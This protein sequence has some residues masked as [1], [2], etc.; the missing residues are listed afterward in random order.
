MKKLIKHRGSHNQYIK[1][2]TYEAI[3][4]AFDDNLYVGVEFD[5]RETLDHEFVIYHNSLYK[6][7]PISSIKYLELPKYIPRLRDILKIKTAKI[8]LVEIKEIKSIDKFIKLLNKYS[9]KKIYVM[10]FIN[11]YIKKIDVVNRQY[12]IGLLNYVLNTEEYIKKL[13]FICILNNLLNKDIINNLNYLEIFS[14]GIIEKISKKEYSNVYY[15][16]DE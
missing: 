4:K 15:I 10:S 14:Y 7:K 2:N 6:G 13:D 16:V 3:K 11:S 8:F 5:V 9:S 1:E 12:K